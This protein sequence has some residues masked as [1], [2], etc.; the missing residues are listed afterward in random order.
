MDV[1]DTGDEFYLA[2]VDFP[3]YGVRFPEEEL[4]QLL[5]GIPEEKAVI[6]LAYSPE[7][8][9]L[10]NSKGVDLVLSGDSH[11]G[12]VSIPGMER[13]FA[14]LGR[15]EYI[16][17]LYPFEGGNLYVNRGIA[18]KGLPARFLCPPEVTL[19]EFVDN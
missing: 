19:F 11:G 14:G 10:C 12:Q 3:G 8:A 5:R 6:F 15:S 2:G 4:D 9:E 1:S 16:R 7:I 18:T 17:G 13:F